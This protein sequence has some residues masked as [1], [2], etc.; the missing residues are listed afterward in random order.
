M[1][2]YEIKERILQKQTFSSKMAVNRELLE[3]KQLPEDYIKEHLEYRINAYIFSEQM[4][5]Y[6][7]RVPLNW[8]EYLK[9]DHA[10][11]WFLKRWPIQWHETELEAF[12]LFPEYTPPQGV[13]QPWSIIREFPHMNWSYQ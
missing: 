11:S 8:W 13:G 1:I 5:C 3:F 12:A 6:T 7:V 4:G 10:P 9:K 2:D